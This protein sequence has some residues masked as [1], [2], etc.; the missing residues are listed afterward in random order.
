MRESFDNIWNPLLKAAKSQIND[1]H[2]KAN[3]LAGYFSDFSEIRRIEL[4]GTA[5]RSEPGSEQSY[6]LILV[7]S[8]DLADQWYNDIV[9]KADPASVYES[10]DARMRVE[11]ACKLL[12]VDLTDLLQST[13]VELEE[14]DI[15][16]F[17]EKWRNRANIQRLN[18][19]LKARLNKEAIKF[20][21]KKGSFNFPPPQ[22]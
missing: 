14:L 22:Q 9:A 1:S 21:P 8:E 6:G 16:L 2:N 3:R 18:P 13:G 11:T 7:V 10:H 15:F 17:Q 20:N 12:A 19:P 5:A 4:F